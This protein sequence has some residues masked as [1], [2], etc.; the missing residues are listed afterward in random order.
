M[1]R[2]Q[3]VEVH[4]D[5]YV[6]VLRRGDADR[7]AVVDP[8]DAGPVLAALHEEGLGV[9]AVLITHHHL[10][11]VGGLAELIRRFHPPVYGPATEPVPGV[12]RPVRGGDRVSVPEIGATFEVVDLP[13]HTSGHVGYVGPDLVLVGDTLF[14]GG[15]GR[16]FEGTFEQMHESLMRLA[17]LPPATE[18][19]CAHEYTVA[20]L[21]F[22]RAVEPDNH[23]LADRLEAAAAA[24]ADGLPTVPSTIAV[25]LRT[26][27]FLRC[28]EAPVIAAAEA[29][30][31]RSLPPGAE[32]FGV[33]RS[34]KDGWS[35]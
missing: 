20:N 15:C 10:D 35:G 30:A 31:G 5:N 1:L 34:W 18:V 23:E 24:R 32:V 17:A 6:W 11:H 8:G 4:S 21:R 27:P 7:V 9:A 14:A 25:E 26:N 29:R 19:Y 22:A 3:P 2:I 33:I 12:D 28:S 16:V 13:G